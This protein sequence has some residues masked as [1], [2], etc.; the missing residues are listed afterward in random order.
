MAPNRGSL[1]E[2]VG[3]VLVAAV[4]GGCGSSEDVNSPAQSAEEQLSPAAP[5]ALVP[6][7]PPMALHID[8]AGIVDRGRLTHSGLSVGEILDAIEDASIDDPDA[9]DAFSLVEPCL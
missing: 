3:G 8:Y 5:V 9:R 6:Q 4:L 7:A 2:I 1:R